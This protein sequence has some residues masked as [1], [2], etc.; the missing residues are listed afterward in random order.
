MNYSLDVV[1]H[2]T[3]WECESTLDEVDKNQG[4]RPRRKSLFDSPSLFLL[5]ITSGLEPGQ[6]S[7]TTVLTK[8]TKVVTG[9]PR[10]YTRT[11]VSKL[12]VPARAR[13]ENKGDLPRVTRTIGVRS[14]QSHGQTTKVWTETSMSLSIGHRIVTV[15]MGPVR[16]G[17]TAS[18]VYR[19]FTELENR[20]S[21]SVGVHALNFY[22]NGRPGHADQKAYHNLYVVALVARLPI[23]AIAYGNRVF[24]H[25]PG[26]PKPGPTKSVATTLEVKWSRVAIAA[27]AIVAS[28]IL[29]ITA[30]MYYCRN[31]F[32][33]EDRHLTTAELLKPVLNN[34][35]DGT[36]MTG[37][38]FESA[39][40][41]VLG[42]PIS[43]GTIPSSQGD[44]P[45]VALGCGAGS[46]FPGFPPFRKRSI[47]RR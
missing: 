1:Y 26:G 4:G 36:T 16:M 28:Q 27:S 5:P 6:V 18:V 29:E 3:A 17:R 40:D 34:I 7:S 30:V 35:D 2:E 14:P 24:P 23:V 44:Q 8:T 37:E 19:S 32:V 12:K 9:Y 47:F 43:Y 15:T 45:R 20:T 21:P 10:T 13:G 11:S 22:E 25:M 42:D 31:V 33:P 39:L 41:K 38:E 46:N